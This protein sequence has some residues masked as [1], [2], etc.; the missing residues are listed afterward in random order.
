MSTV[1]V[2]TLKET[3]IAKNQNKNG[4]LVA[5]DVDALKCNSS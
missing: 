1:W 3:E 4:I 2:L 5:I